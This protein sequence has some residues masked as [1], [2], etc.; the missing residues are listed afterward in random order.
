MCAGAKGVLL[1]MNRFL[2]VAAGGA[3]GAAA[4]YIVSSLVMRLIP[5]EFPWGTLAVN[6]SGAVMIGIAWALFSRAAN[7][8][9][10]AEL[11]LLIG[12][13]GAFTTFSTYRLETFSMIQLRDYGKAAANVIANN[14]LSVGFV[15]LSYYSCMRIFRMMGGDL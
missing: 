5:T 13:L 11:F 15:F 4:R 9:P 14:I 3:I 7:P 1:M 8:S 12:V 10:N 6:A 2:L